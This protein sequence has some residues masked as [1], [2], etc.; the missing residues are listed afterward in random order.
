MF[1]LA[2]RNIILTGP[3][4]GQTIHLRRGSVELLPDWVAETDYC[5]ALIAEGKIVASGTKDRD[6][7]AAEEKKTR[8]RRGSQTTEE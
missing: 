2:K 1:V 3:E 6:L 8:V 7:Q 4:S 5:K